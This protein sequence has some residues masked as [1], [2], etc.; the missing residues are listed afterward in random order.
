MLQVEGANG[1]GKTSLLR[2]L[3]QLIPPESGEVR[4]GGREIREIRSEYLH[5]VCYVGHAHGIKTGLTPRENLQVAAAL[6]GW[7]GRPAS[8][9]AAL[10]RLALLECEDIP[11]CQL[12][13]GQGRRVALARLLLSSAQLWILDE[14]FTALDQSGRQAI[15][16]ILE[17]HCAAGGMAVF[18]THQPINLTNGP[19]TPIHLG[20]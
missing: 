18:T 16:G 11:V 8:L 10:E 12:S 19:V 20:S 9:E 7:G 3:C 6:T 14:P 15:K 5:E 17:S 1:S 13:A 2:I 4:W